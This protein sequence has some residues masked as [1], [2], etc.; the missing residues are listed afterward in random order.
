MLHETNHILFLSLQKEEEYG[1]EHVQEHTHLRV[2][3]RLKW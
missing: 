1:E 2:P 3:G